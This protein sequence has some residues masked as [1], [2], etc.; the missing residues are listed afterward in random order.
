MRVS[1][2]SYELWLRLWHRPNEASYDALFGK[3]GW[4][5]IK[6]S[7]Q[8]VEDLI[9]QTS[10]ILRLRVPLKTSNAAGSLASS[11]GSFFGRA[12]S[13]IASTL[14]NPPGAGKRLKRRAAGSQLHEVPIDLEPG[15]PQSWQLITGAIDGFL[16]T[17]KPDELLLKRIVGVLGPNQYLKNKIDDLE[18]AVARLAKETENA[19]ELLGHGDKPKKPEDVEKKKTFRAV[20]SDIIKALRDSESHLKYG[21]WFLELEFPSHVSDG[22]IA[23]TQIIRDCSISFVARTTLPTNAT[24]TKE[25]RLQR[26]RGAAEDEPEPEDIAGLARALEDFHTKSTWTI[27]MP[28]R[29]SPPLYQLDW[30]QISPQ[31]ITKDWREVLDLCSQ[32]QEKRKALELERAHFALGLTLWFILLWETDWFDHVCSCGF[33]CVLYHKEDKRDDVDGNAGRDETTDVVYRPEHVYAALSLRQD[34]EADMNAIPEDEPYQQA[35]PLPLTSC[36]GQTSLKHRLY[37]FGMLLAELALATPIHLTS[38]LNHVPRTASFGRPVEKFKRIGDIRNHRDLPP[39]LKQAI[40]F[41]FDR[42]KEEKWSTETKGSAASRTQDFLDNVVKPVKQYYDVVKEN[43]K[44][45]RQFADLAQDLE[46]E[47]LVQFEDAQE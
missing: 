40:E 12:A 47:D 26:L 43:F 13:S 42:V 27:T 38:D 11:Q 16:V 31:F 24:T 34:A 25:L 30:S 3:D 15:D 29:P 5:I 14:R 17:Y 8:D 21:S 33:R 10:D 7:R 44:Y 45:A 2:Q 46:D 19:F 39:Q 35:A 37:H 4:P 22:E 9:I 41:C 6:Q 18:K 1:A 28:G 23:L 20:A 36:R 32:N